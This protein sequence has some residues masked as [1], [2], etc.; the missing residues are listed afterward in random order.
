MY[1]ENLDDDY[2]AELK[3]RFWAKVDKRGPDECW[4]WTAGTQN[5]Y[6]K[7][8]L[9][10]RHVPAHRVSYELVKGPLPAPDARKKTH[11]LHKC[12]NSL[13]VNPNH[14]FVGTH[15][16][17]MRDKVK[18]G[19][20]VRGEKHPNSKLTR[21]DVIKM[22]NLRKNKRLKYKDIARK[23]GISPGH[24]CHVINGTCWPHV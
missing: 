10:G 21:D 24:A 5:E 13:C 19:R 8:Y 1:L 6:G 16:D 11:A 7:F 14:I 18:K 9:K 3:V 20:H 22:R 15:L 12:D 4:E 2:L 23:F 17:N